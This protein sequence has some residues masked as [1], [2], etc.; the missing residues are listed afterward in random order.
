MTDRLAITNLAIFAHHG[1][2]GGENEIGQR[3]FID[4][5]V[6]TDIREAAR[7]RSLAKTIDYARLAEVITQ[8]FLEKNEQLLETVIERIATRVLET[9]DLARAVEVTIRKP[10]VP[11]DAIVDHVSITIRRSRDA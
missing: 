10:S 1:V 8:A 6:D 9:F 4:V 5:A 2:Y 11:I 7:T 3:F